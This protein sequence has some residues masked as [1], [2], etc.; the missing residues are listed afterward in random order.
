MRLHPL[1]VV[2]RVGTRIAGVA[3]GLAIAVFAGTTA[4][5]FLSTLQVAA[6][7]AVALLA[8]VGYEVARYRR[9]EYALTDSTLDVSSGV[10]ARRERE[11]PL[12]RVQNVDVS[13]NIVQR[14]L[15]IATVHVE[16]AGGGSTEAVLECVSVAEAERL[17]SEIRR[18]KRAAERAESDETTEEGAATAEG[19][20]A[21]ADVEAEEDVFVL[22]RRHLL[23]ASALSFD[24]RLVS[25]VFVA[26][27]FIWPVLAP[28]LGDLNRVAL[29]AVSVLGVVAL[30]FGLW[31]ASAARTFARYYDFRL[32]RVGD[33]LRYERGLGER[34]TGTIP[35]EKLQTVVVRETALQ[36][37]FGYA[38]LTVETA[39]YAPGSGPSGGSEAAVPL[40]ARE[41]VFALARELEAFDVPELEPAPTRARRRYA[42]RYAIGV[43][44]LLALAGVVNYAVVSYPFWWAPAVFF[45]LVP[46]AAHY[47]WVHLGVA[48]DDD[49][50]FTRAGFWTRRTHVVPH[51]RVQTLI[52]R[53]SL[54][55]RR[56]DLASV[57]VDTAGSGGLL[58]GDAVA[59]D[60]DAEHAAALVET[61]GERMR[62]T[63][64]ARRGE[65]GD[66]AGERGASESASH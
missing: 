10:F 47:K 17:Q 64:A 58:G 20:T 34:Y 38:S 41:E 5:P 66:D 8:F 25:V 3:W 33:D 26:Q 37:Y 40:A 60:I 7:A 56:W 32:T 21:V 2:Y 61:A 35:L 30:V 22:D 14:A 4:V 51:Y 1:S 36:R 12:R 23:L 44:L 18:L 62:A 59:L 27:P 65:S 63:L 39:G 19:E 24:T 9:F 53:A 29:A 48:V 52:E 31:V 16:T 15:G 55:Q 46:V 50:A 57:V 6:I 42:G 49:H 54:F 28:V 43:G 11:I 45:A 13:R